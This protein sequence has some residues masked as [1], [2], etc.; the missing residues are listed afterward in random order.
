MIPKHIHTNTLFRKRQKVSEYP[1]EPYLVRSNKKEEETALHLCGRN[2]D[3]RAYPPFAKMK[4][5]PVIITKILWDGCPVQ[6]ENAPRHI[7]KLT[8]HFSEMNSYDHAT[9]F[10]GSK[11]FFAEDILPPFSPDNQPIA[12]KR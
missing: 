5:K 9:W 11:T 8:V 3:A 1:Y 2:K 7:T 6:R 10:L 4:I 12:R